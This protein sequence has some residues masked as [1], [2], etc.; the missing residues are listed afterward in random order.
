MKGSGI[1]A[2]A[3][4]YLLGDEKINAGALTTFNEYTVASENRLTPI[5]KDMPLDKAALIGCAISTGAG[6]IFNTA[7]VKPGNSVAVFGAGGVGLS[8]IQASALSLANPIIAVD[9]SEANLVRAQKFGAT[10]IIHAKK[11]DPVSTIRELTANLGA[12]AAVESAGVRAS[13]EQAFDCVRRGGLAVLI[14]NLPYQEKISIDPFELI[15][16]KRIVGS[17]GGETDPDKDFPRY[18]DRY[19]SGKL[20]LDEL[21][22]HRFKLEEINRAFDL[23]EQGALGRAIIEF[24]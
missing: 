21:I 6:A 4:Q 13:M 14:G 19:C 17:W 7:K 5:R 10:R 8:A 11:E 12:D 22:T 23:M 24:S 15:C 9:I 16:G 20:K 2:S 1:N 18:V 3:V